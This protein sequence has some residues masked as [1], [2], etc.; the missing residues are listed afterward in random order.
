VRPRSITRFVGRGWK[1]RDVDL[2]IDGPT[3]VIGS[4]G[5]GKSLVLDGV[6]YALTGDAPSGTALDAVVRHFGLRGGHVSLSDASGSTIV[7]GLV[8]EAR[9]S[10]GILSTSRDKD[11]VVD[12]SDWSDTVIGLDLP[13]FVAL[14]PAKR[15]DAVAD[16]LQVDAEGG[17]MEALDVGVDREVLVAGV[18]AKLSES[19]MQDQIAMYRG[20][21]R[22]E[23]E[24]MADGGFPRL[25]EMFRERKLAANR[26]QK[27]WA[28]AQEK[29]EQEAQGAKAAAAQLSVARHEEAE[30]VGAVRKLELRLAGALEA[31]RAMARA[32]KSQLT[33][34]DDYEYAV[35]QLEAAVPAVPVSE[36]ALV[37]VEAER[38]I[39]DM[40]LEVAIAARK[41]ADHV[42]HE[43]TANE[44]RLATLRESDAAQMAEIGNR[45]PDVIHPLIPQFKALAYGLARTVTDEIGLLEL[46]LTELRHA[47]EAPVPSL[48]DVEQLKGWAQAA[49]ESAKAIYRRV[50]DAQKSE[51]WK[52][53]C[54]AAIDAARTAGDRAQKDLLDSA[55]ALE[56]FGAPPAALRGEVA[57]EKQTLAHLQAALIEAQKAAGV[58]DAYRRASE[59]AAEQH[60]LFLAAQAVEKAA[61]RLRDE[62]AGSKAKLLEGELREV[63]MALGRTEPP[64]VELEA[65]R[66]RPA[67]SLGWISG[68]TMVPIEALSSGE[69]TV[70]MLSLSIA[71]LRHVPGRRV[72]LLEADP[73]DAK[74]LAAVLRGL[75]AY[76]GELDLC[77]IATHRRIPDVQGWKVVRC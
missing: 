69:A 14:S 76:A 20:T 43:I 48:E 27:K 13:A 8:T 6:R 75:V 47:A 67:F 33:A 63:L 44:L 18:T 30:Q 35:R 7:R 55:K 77:L 15:R 60:V 62:A 72:L 1:G 38:S 54:Q 41:K 53:Q 59:Q 32:S 37:E 16:L 28:A 50:A 57:E 51:G 22:G 71:H 64:W 31:E 39:A 58:I 12:L 34:K 29:L 52:A 25:A 11:G 73:L 2:E 65:Q 21:L 68:E 5:S 61:L 42:A 49:A 4:N 19:E 9:G 74:R 36:K 56:R 3:I 70:L 40:A 24:A 26:D 45:I 17:V 10:K 66:G 23:A 46:D